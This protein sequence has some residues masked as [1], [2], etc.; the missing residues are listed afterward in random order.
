M[1]TRFDDAAYR[2]SQSPRARWTNDFVAAYLDLVA[3][4]GD[5]E[6]LVDWACGLY[7]TRHDEDPRAVAAAMAARR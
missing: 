2:A 3:G 1:P 5:V 7:A 4:A 6:D